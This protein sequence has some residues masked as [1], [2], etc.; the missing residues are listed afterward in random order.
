MTG[1]VSS[2]K[3]C[4]CGGERWYVGWQGHWYEREGDEGFGRAKLLWFTMWRSLFDY[5]ERQK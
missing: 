1:V 5:E 4:L 3:R 2:R